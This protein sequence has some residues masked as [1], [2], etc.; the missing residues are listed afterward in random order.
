MAAEMEQAI[1][2]REGDREEWGDSWGVSVLPF[3]CFES[4]ERSI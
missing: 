3:A 1:H 4:E 2:K